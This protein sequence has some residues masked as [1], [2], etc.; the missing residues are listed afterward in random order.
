MIKIV[1]G[2]QLSYRLLHIKAELNVLLLGMYAKTGRR[3]RI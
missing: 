3:A 1:A 2:T